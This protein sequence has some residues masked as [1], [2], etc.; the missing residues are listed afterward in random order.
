MHRYLP[1]TALITTALATTTLVAIASPARAETISTK[2]T[3]PVQTSTIK[4]GTPDSITIDAAGS[5][6]LTGGT[7]VTMDS[8]NAVTNG[9]KIIVTSAGNA[10]GGT[11][12][13]ANAGTAGD[14]VNSGTITV[15]EPYAPTDTDND[16]DIDGPFALGGNR[17]GIRTL[18]DHT[19]KLVNSGTI[20]VEGNDSYGI[21][22][23]GKLTGAFTHD[24]KTTVL[25]DRS[26]G[27]DAGA[28]DGNVRL[29]GTVTATGK[30][31]IGAR[32]SGDVNGAM[33]VQGT[34]ASTGYRYT[35]PPSDASK[36]D[37]DDLLQGGSALVIEGNVSG[38]I[39]LA[40]PPKDNDTTKPDE[41][42]D[43]IEDAKEGSARV[44]TFGSAAAMVVGA[45]DHAIT[46]G[47]VAGTASGYGLQID[48][49]I[50]GRGLYA[51]VDA[52]GLVVG[53]RGGAVSIAN[54]I[55]IAGSVTA[56]SNGA[57]A[58]AVRIGS[59]TTTP[60]LRVS[61]Q[62]NAGGGTLARG[63]VVDAG[64][65]LGTIRNSGAIKAASSTTGT[66]V[67][68]V[69]LSGGV[70]LVENS[71]TISATGS[72]ASTGRTIAI[73]LSANTTGT[74]VRQTVVGATFAA[75]S[76]VGDV[77][78]GSGNDT[79]ELADGTM[80]GSVLFGTGAN[81]LILSGDAVQ[82][83]NATFG[84]GNDTMSLA[85]TSKFVGI[86]DFG[87]GADTLA[88]SGTSLFSGSL[89]NA[90][91]LA[92]SVGGGTLD[93]AKP[94]TIGSLSVGS[95]GVL[96]VTLNKA[97]GQGT[98]YTVGGTASFASG[99]KLSLR[100]ADVTT[101]VGSYTVLT[102]V[103]LQGASNLTA[104]TTLVPFLFK[105][106]LATNAPANTVVVDIAR[107]TTTELGLNGSESLAFD[108]IFAAL[109]KDD[110][111]EGVFLAITDGETFGDT[112]AAMLPDHAGGAFEGVSMG[113][114]SLTR[115]M[116]DPRGPIAYSGNLGVYANLNFW[117]SDKKAGDTAAYNL[118]GYAWSLMGEYKTGIGSFSAS[119]AYMWNQHTRGAVG[120]VQATS[121]EL[122]AGWRGDWGAFSA[123]GRASIGT[124][125]FKG[126]R[127]FSGTY[128][129]KAVDKTIKGE[130]DGTFMSLAG[131]LSAEGGGSHFF[132][133]PAVS[134]DYVT[135]KED[136]YSEAGGGDALD[137][138]INSRKSSELGA[139][140]GLTLGV[141]FYGNAKN[142]DNWL[143]LETEGGWREILS[144]G[145][146]KTTARFKDGT[147]F[148]LTGNDATGGWFARARLFGGTG[149][150][151]VGGELGAEDRHDS[152]NLS[153]RGTMRIGF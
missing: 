112:V 149:G 39:V 116:L 110:D 7:A 16:G 93:I 35:T 33:V 5:V 76:I 14:I 140:A 53:G 121:Y 95:G 65:N 47:A 34:I 98:A 81:S 68:I 142:A 105:A 61:G 127:T 74:T 100:L 96:A 12:I 26:I 37:A 150:F 60:E 126:K 119:A 21:S 80:T 147:P 17:Y 117:G 13:L 43:G 106:S 137:L 59:G 133:R 86:A 79:L 41:D 125:Q 40:V 144:G 69:D 66:A 64:A 9:G 136:G 89:T 138:T 128:G 44:V 24:G 55:G 28:I 15:D 29:A 11:G 118:N 4:A 130:W 134:V 51:N 75:P 135:L 148:T 32:F 115:Q 84:A 101:A 91:N 23:G 67:A 90:G 78:L 85:G 49:S 22:L 30:D 36:L 31:A 2:R 58:T 99:S 82:T 141:D 97:A 62:I 124:G 151:T 109:G 56:A 122:A 143:R 48:G 83:G 52:N 102:A 73:D 94:T 70:T 42:S 77:L 72:L 123:F 88:L 153:L 46:I 10:N 19:G 152:V 129:G 120:S 27:V 57:S 111:V 107:R 92:V 18:G 139:N 103:D 108:A 50:E 145:I 25:G 71:G 104:D 45:T 146:G 87:G 113:V 6:E 38:G 114:R 131:G 63:V 1:K 8:D 132:Y 20:T 54:G 3:A